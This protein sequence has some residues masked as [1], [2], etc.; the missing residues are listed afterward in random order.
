MNFESSD[1]KDF[2][3]QGSPA[4]AQAA[5]PQLGASLLDVRWQERDLCL[6]YSKN[7]SAITSLVVASRYD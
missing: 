1:K 2:I 6:L 3:V 5:T 4:F 7:L